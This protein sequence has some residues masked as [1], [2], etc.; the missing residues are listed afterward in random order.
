MA[1]DRAARLQH[2]Q[3]PAQGVVRGPGHRAVRQRQL[4][5]VAGL[6]VRVPRRTAQGVCSGEGSLAPRV[7]LGQRDVAQGIGLRDHL[8]VRVVP[9]DRPAAEGVRVRRRARGVVVGEG[10]VE[11]PV[12]ALRTDHPAPAVVDVR[13]GGAVPVGPGGDPVLG[14]VGEAQGFAAGVD[15]LGEVA[16]RVVGVAHHHRPAAGGGVLVPRRGLVQQAQRGDPRAVRVDGQ[17]VAA[18][19]PDRGGVALGRAF[20]VHAGAV[21]VLP[22]LQGQVDHALG[23]AGRDVTE[24]AYD[25]GVRIGDGDD[26][27]RGAVPLQRPARALR[28]QHRLPGPGHRIHQP[29]PVARREHHALRVELQR[30]VQRRDPGGAEARTRAVRGEVRAL[31]EQRQ[32]PRQLHI[33]L[34]HQHRAGGHVH[35]LPL[36]GGLAR[37][38]GE[39]ALLDQVGTQARPQQVLHAAELSRPGRD[40]A[41]G[42]EHPAPDHAALRGVGDLV[43]AEAVL[44]PQR[45]PYGLGDGRVDRHREDALVDRAGQHPRGDR[46]HRRLDLHAQAGRHLDDPRGHLVRPAP[47]ED[48]QHHPA[49]DGDRVD[50]DLLPQRLDGVI[51]RVGE[52]LQRLGHLPGSL[53]QIAEPAAVLALGVALPERLEGVDRL[54][55]VVVDEGGGLPVGR[56]PYVV[57][58]VG[59]RPPRLGGVP[60]R[61]GIGVRPPH[62]EVEEDLLGLVLDAHSAPLPPCAP[63]SWCFSFSLVKIPAI[64]LS[65]STCPSARSSSASWMLTR[66]RMATPVTCSSFFWFGL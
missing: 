7:P 42:A 62:A 44:L 8:A 6:V 47:G 29:H 35:R 13:E 18:G 63:P 16:R 60:Q 59:E 61:P 51:D 64:A 48:G 55:R 49:R 3:R 9:A 58:A 5:E 21:A 32:A 15:D 65:L 4:G 36:A 28:R 12:A 31:E 53:R 41:R 33:R 27:V 50:A 19:V 23:R 14:V 45:D 52:F 57:D 1:P 22:G 46:G 17:V 37:R 38:A 10:T 30:L 2:L 39:R 26:A 24:G 11:D 56:A 34:R 25:T 43:Q 20:H 66:P 40:R 54:T